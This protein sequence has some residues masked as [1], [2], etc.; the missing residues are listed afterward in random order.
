MCEQYRLKA[1]NEFVKVIGSCGHKFFNHKGHYAHFSI[2]E[3]GRVFFHDDY[4][5]HKIYLHVKYIT[6]RRF[7]H[8]GTLGNFVLALKDYIKKGH[9]LNPAY[10]KTRD[11]IIDGHAWAYGED[12][13]IVYEAGLELGII[14][15][16][17]HEEGSE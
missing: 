12:L 6:S 11:W 8:G 4:S 9:Q 1:V 16:P 2:S 17:L 13:K 14:A 7:S 15:P 5:R 3:F 10:F